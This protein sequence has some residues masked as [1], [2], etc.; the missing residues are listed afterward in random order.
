VCFGFV[1]DCGFRCFSVVVGLVF[2]FLS[3]DF[4]AL[5]V[6]F[7][8]GAVIWVWYNTPSGG[9]GCILGVFFA[10]VDACVLCAEIVF[11]GCFS[12]LL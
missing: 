3:F 7:L 9:F 11:F 1:V 6:W 10:L 12:C 2:L 8:V 5:V 4:A